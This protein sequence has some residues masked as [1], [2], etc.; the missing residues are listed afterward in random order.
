[1]LYNGHF[2]YHTYCIFLQTG[3]YIKTNTQAANTIIKKLQSIEVRRGWLKHAL[4][5][6]NTGQNTEDIYFNVYKLRM[7]INKTVCE[8]L[9]L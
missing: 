7:Q 6:C 8:L 1:M 4:Y 3:K 2:F 5:S 9:F